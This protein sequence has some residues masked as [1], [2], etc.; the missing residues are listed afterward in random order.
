MASFPDSQL[1]WLLIFVTVAPEIF[2][3]KPISQKNPVSK[4]S[5]KNF[6]IEI[7]IRAEHR[8]TLPCDGCNYSENKRRSKDFLTA[9]TAVPAYFTPDIEP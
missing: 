4:H 2:P 7:E 1:D 9:A 8:S 3:A 5:I 6:L